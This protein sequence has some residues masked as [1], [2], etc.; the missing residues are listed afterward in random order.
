MRRKDAAP[1]KEMPPCFRKCSRG[2]SAKR[3]TP[4]LLALIGG[5]EVRHESRV[6]PQTFVPLVEF[7]KS[8][9]NRNVTLS[10]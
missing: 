7:E 9:R 6:K 4:R 10:F 5:V 8:K 3:L 2:R 1:A